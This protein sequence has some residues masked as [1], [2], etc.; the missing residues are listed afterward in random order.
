M[1]P[2]LMEMDLFARDQRMLRA[3]QEV[4]KRY[5]IEETGGGNPVCFRVAHGKTEYAVGVTLD[6]S[7]PA[8]CTCPDAVYRA[9]N[10]NR[11]FCKH[12]IAVLMKDKRLSCQLLDLIL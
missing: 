11:G 1:E 6:W 7:E 8:S 9:R 2:F 5:E 12:I 3:A 4:S 10:C